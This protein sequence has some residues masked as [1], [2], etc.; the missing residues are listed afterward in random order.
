MPPGTESRS[1]KRRMVCIESTVRQKLVLADVP[2]AI[3]DDLGAQLGEIERWQIQSISNTIQQLEDV[4]EADSVARIL[5]GV[6]ERCKKRI[7]TVV[8]QGG[9][10]IRLSGDFVDEC[11]LRFNQT[12]RYNFRKKAYGGVNN[13]A[14]EQIQHIGPNARRGI[15]AKLRSSCEKFNNE[16]GAQLDSLRD[17]QGGIDGGVGNLAQT[18]A[19]ELTENGEIEENKNK[20]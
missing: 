8:N 6:L 20:S 7:T 10:A 4:K 5:N 9:D 14:N 17:V 3:R 1:I 15:L 12:Q 18:V 16:V 11:D 13:Y 19:N 2:S